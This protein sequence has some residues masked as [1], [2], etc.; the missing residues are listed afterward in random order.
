MKGKWFKFNQN[1][2]KIYPLTEAYGDWDKLI[3]ITAAV[4][5]AVYKFQN[6]KTKKI[7]SISNKDKKISS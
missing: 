7:G 1:K 4:F 3:K 5:R 6:L 2:Q